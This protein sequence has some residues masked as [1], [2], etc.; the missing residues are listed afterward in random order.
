MGIP[1]FNAE[2]SLYGKNGEQFIS[3]SK[4]LNQRTGEMV[5]LALLNGAEQIMPGPG[6]LKPIE[7]CKWNKICYKD[8]WT[9]RLECFYVKTCRW[10]RA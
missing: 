9:G 7:F 2:A 1:G 6:D 8:P 5:F 4:S 3:E 10:P